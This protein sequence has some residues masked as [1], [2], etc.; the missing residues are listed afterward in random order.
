MHGLNA[1]LWKRINWWWKRILVMYKYARQKCIKRMIKSIVRALSQFGS[2]SIMTTHFLQKLLSCNKLSAIIVVG[3][4]HKL[5][6]L[7]LVFRL[8]CLLWHA[9]YGN[10]CCLL[11][12]FQY[13]NKHVNVWMLYIKFRIQMAVKS[14]TSLPFDVFRRAVHPFIVY[15]QYSLP[16]W[17]F[18]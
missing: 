3:R 8:P 14:T 6:L 13:I 12:L 9:I 2:R 15:R 1:F 11:N 18:R 5:C 7:S 10:I 4:H 17:S 16:C